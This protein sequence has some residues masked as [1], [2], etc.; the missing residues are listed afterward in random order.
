MKKFALAAAAA[1]FFTA[2][3]KCKDPGI[4]CTEEFRMIMLKIESPVKTPV[5][6]DSFYTLRVSNGERIRP[7]QGMQPGYYV[8]L[9]DSYQPRLKGKEED[10]RFSGWRGGQQVVNQAYRIAADN[11]HISKRSGADSV[12]VQ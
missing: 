8:V 1:L 5:T 7:Q 4:I 3:E 10:F 6:L 11:C 12:T 2:C 9:D